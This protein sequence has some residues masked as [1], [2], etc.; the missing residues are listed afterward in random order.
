VRANTTET[1][2]QLAKKQD[3]QALT[4]LLLQDERQRLEL[5]EQYLYAPNA[6]INRLIEQLPNAIVQSDLQSLYSALNFDQAVQKTLK[7][8]INNDAEAYADAL[9]PV[10]FP[11]I[12]KSITEAIKEFIE[13]INVTLEQSLSL[14][15]V[16][17]HIEAWRGGLEYRDVVLKHTVNFQVEQAFLIHRETGLLLRHSSIDGIDLQRDSD[18]VSSMLTAIQDFIQDSFSGEDGG[19]L[20]TVEVGDYT[21]YL[22]R[23]SYSV[24]AC[25]IQGTPPISLRSHFQGILQS[26]HAQYGALLRDFEGDSEPLAV[27]E[28]L[29]VECLLSERKSKEKNVKNQTKLF[30]IGTPILLLLLSLSA[31]W[32]YQEW[33]FKQRTQAYISHLNTLS[34]VVVTSLDFTNQ[35]LVLKGLYD[36][37]VDKSMMR[38]DRFQLKPEE[39]SSHWQP[40]Q[41]LDPYFLLS[42]VDRFLAPPKSVKLQLK[43]NSLFISGTAKESWIAG[44]NLKL[45]H[46]MGINSINTQHLTSYLTHI[47]AVLS[48]PESVILELDEVFGLTLQGEASLRWLEGLVGKLARLDRLTAVNSSQLYSFES[49]QLQQLTAELEQF[50]IYFDINQADLNAKQQARVLLV[51]DKLKTVLALSKALDKGVTLIVTGYTDNKGSIGYNRRLAK[52]RSVNF[53]DFLKANGVSEAVN[54]VVNSESDSQKLPAKNDMLSRKISLK[55]DFYSVE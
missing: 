41:S 47:K 52:N 49:M 32:M 43:H 46:I 48:P 55:F 26:I 23:S 24:L 6:D 12:K 18:A 54:L 10:I 22:T 16:S 45:L 19:S 15:R 50:E 33:D 28:P 2:E 37:L 29:L 8:S 31:Y 7:D 13:T 25:V 53:I 9:Y 44:L 36:P 51:S 39:L 30:Y 17:W 1:L 35:H 4:A 40:Y 27:I 34:G 11:S 20:D 14:E 3:H 42:R 21:V 5:I 38:A